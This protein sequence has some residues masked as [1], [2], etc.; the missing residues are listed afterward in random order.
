MEQR[1]SI[2]S[3]GA[4]EPLGGRNTGNP[5]GLTPLSSLS[6]YQQGIMR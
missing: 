3:K 1:I 2:F 5:Y 4:N 6:L